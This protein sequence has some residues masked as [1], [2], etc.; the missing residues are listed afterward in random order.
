MH[1]TKLAKKSLKGDEVL[2]VGDFAENYLFVV[3][4]AAIRKRVAF[5]LQMGEEIERGNL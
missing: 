3:Q 5:S 1:L 4:N 2:I